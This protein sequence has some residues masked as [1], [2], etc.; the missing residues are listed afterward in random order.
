M[1]PR[2]WLASLA[3]TLHVF[4]IAV[5][6]GAVLMRARLLRSWLDRGRH[7]G[8]I[9]ERRRTQVAR[10][11]GLANSAAPCWALLSRRR[12]RG[13]QRASRH[14]RCRAREPR[15][16]RRPDATS[17]DRPRHRSPNLCRPF[18][19]S[20]Y[21]RAMNIKQ[22]ALVFGA[23]LLVSLIVTCTNGARRD[24]GHAM[25]DAGNWIADGDGVPDTRRRPSP[26]GAGSGRFAASSRRASAGRASRPRTPTAHRTSTASP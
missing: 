15:S 9:S 4:G 10:A 17:Y 7:V 16:G 18:D 19:P 2:E 11:I 8:Q 14:R 5:A 20:A 23:G 3:S 22:I 13:F 12:P 26:W 24:F 21:D 25:V 6:L 1:R